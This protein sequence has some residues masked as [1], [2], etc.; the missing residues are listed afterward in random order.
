MPLTAHLAELRARAIKAL[1]VIGLLTALGFTFG[2]PLMKA[3][4][5][6]P[7][8]ALDPE[9]ANPLARFNPLVARLRPLLTA[10]G[11]PRR[12]DLHAM[13]VMEVFIVKL[14]LS[15]LAGIVLGAPWALYQMW[16]FIEAGLTRGERRVVLCYLPFSIALF[17]GGVLFAYLAA[18]PA[19][20][21][22][23]LS[24]DVH[25]KP[26]LMYGPYFNLVVTSMV[27]FGAAFQVP[28]VIMALA[29]LG[30]VSGQALAAKRRHA[31]VAM[32]V[33]AAIL[34]PPDPF[35]QCLLAAPLVLLF[36]VGVFLA[37]RAERRAA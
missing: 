26:L 32:F 15:L 5:T 24:V 36:E 31:V 29:R 16:A 30:I 7:L 34:T 25:V 11:T 33:I 4:V 17:L 2:Y 28:L 27:V 1:L 6:A 35:T 8:D 10:E 23:L 14:K 13:T 37:R 21:L 3:V 12:V 20:L 19:G 9:T 22:F 18:V